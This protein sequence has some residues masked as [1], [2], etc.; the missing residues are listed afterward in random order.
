MQKR[1][2]ILSLLTT[3]LF[4]CAEGPVRKTISPD[5]QPAVAAQALAEGNY[6]L[7][8]ELYGRLAES[9][10]PPQAYEYR[11]L[12]AQALFQGGLPN[13]AIEQLNQLPESK[14]E[15]ALRMKVQ[16]L[17]AEIPLKRDAHAT[18]ELLGKPAV[19]EGVL[20]EEVGPLY[21]RFYRLRA[22]A[23]AH[24]GNHRAA[25]REYILR[26]LYLQQQEQIEA[27]QLAIWQSLSL[28]SPR[29]LR[30]QRRQP[31]PDVLSGWM[32]LVE[33]SKDYNLSPETMRQQI[34]NWRQRYSGHPASEQVLQ[35][36]LE[37]S[38]ELAERPANIA[39]LLPLS[40]RY[41]AAAR[42]IHDGVLVAYYRD[43]LRSS[44]A[45]HIYDTGEDPQE[46]E[47]I[48][49]QAVEQ[50][51]EFVIGPLDKS[52]VER[53]ADKRA[54]PVPTLALNYARTPDNGQ[55]YQFTLSPE[56]EAR[57]V[58]DRAWQEGHTRAAVLLPESSLG[59]RLFTA[60]A[61]RWQALGGRLVGDTRYDAEGND[62]SI[63]IKALFNITDSE[64]RKRRIN[65]LISGRVEFTPRRRQDVDF[66]F[67]SAFP[68]QARLLRP[69]L[70][71][72]HAGDLPVLATSHLYSG[73]V[74]PDTDRDMDDII[75]CDMPWL[76]DG[77][78]PQQAL[79]QANAAELQTHRGQLQRLVAL[80]VD[81]YQLVPLLP[82]L[83]NHA[84][85]HYRGETGK[86]TV[87]TDHRVERQLLWAQFMR[88]RPQLQEERVIKLDE[89]NWQ[90]SN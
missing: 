47:G 14:L 82:M 66:V 67:I 23:Y 7:A 61:E 63:P 3:L 50:G 49:Q 21:A 60:F 83:E 8:S 68:R 45:L 31:P 28:L 22:R 18:L 46:V 37:R 57:E 44:I 32:E 9:S 90:L 11:Y 30:E 4:G 89:N 55:L 71:F 10:Q 16:L 79:R 6:E 15:P 74:N 38:R 81:A 52:A 59:E 43:P 65:Q 48:Y 42:A 77:D 12:N 78:S 64:V 56:D 13:Q 26:E 27:N 85:E 19:A 53:L 80:G 25:A 29:E 54:L 86:L 51:A 17:R 72:H 2:L 36:L 40:G 76:L 58:A 34:G 62:F 41:A 70:R 20:A 88:G 75:F 73:E 69:Q 39:L 1:L 87:T 35:M 84:Y 33:I 5:D 24:L